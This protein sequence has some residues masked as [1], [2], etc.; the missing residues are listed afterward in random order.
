MSVVDCTLHSPLISLQVV[1]ALCK[2]T[3]FHIR[4]VTRNP[5]NAAAQNLARLP[6]VSI[7]KADFSD[8]ATLV[9]AFEGAEVVYGVT[10]YYDPKIQEGDT[11]EEARQGC[12]MAD[13]AKQTG[14]ELFIWST[15]PSA[16]LRTGAQFNSPRLVENKFTV[17][18]YLKYQNVPHVDLYL[19]F[20]MDN[21][22]NFGCI[23]KA[24]DGAIEISQPV[25]KPDV[26]IG[27]VW[28]ERDLGRTVISILN[29]Y[30][31]M[32]EILGGSVYCISGQYCTSDTGEEIKKQTGS[33]V[34]VVCGQTTGYE[35][36]DRM[37]EYYNRW[38]VYREEEL[39]HSV[40]AK[41]GLNFSSLEDFVR[42]TV[43]PFTKTLKA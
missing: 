19:G 20:F 35:D 22:I 43:V 27:M 36:L 30:R 14:V 6:N 34:R 16:L 8:P 9:A 37:Y 33:S 2:E 3:Q 13:I 5:Q 10:N 17:S 18:Q 26:K 25:L 39:S 4:A 40:T 41:L 12:H 38:G 21:L 42:D 15:V 28:I 1:R 7:V 11:L 32:P 23:S 31:N 29:N 24:K